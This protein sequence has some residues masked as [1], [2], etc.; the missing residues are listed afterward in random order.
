M[1]FDEDEGWVSPGCGFSSPARLISHTT[2]IAQV[3]VPNGQCWPYIP[4]GVRKVQAAPS[5]A[6]FVHLAALTASLSACRRR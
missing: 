4:E 5:A 3:V 6:P 1:M 2:A